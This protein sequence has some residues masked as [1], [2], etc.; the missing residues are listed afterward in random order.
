MYKNLAHPKI[1]KLKPSLL[2]LASLVALDGI[3][4][5]LSTQLTGDLTL[6]WSGGSMFY[7]L[8]HIYAKTPFCCVQPV[9]NN[10]LNR[11]RVVV[12]D[13]LWANA[14]PT[15]NIA[16]SLTNCS[17][18]I[19]NTLPSD[20]FNSSAISRNFNLRSAK[21]SLWSFLVFSGTFKVSIP[22]LNRCFR[23]SRVLI[24][25]MKPLLCLSSIF[26]H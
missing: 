12:F 18:K 14:A 13:R 19:V 23:R 2:M 3:H 7:P 21:T 25:L 4:P 15:L 5:L 20:I 24:I 22:P 1:R 11:R 9:L 8:S 17:C 16:F 26:F 10:A 6:E